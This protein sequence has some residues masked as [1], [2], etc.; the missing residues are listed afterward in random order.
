MTILFLNMET[1]SR[2]MRP[3]GSRTCYQSLFRVFRVLYPSYPVETWLQTY[4]HFGVENL[5]LK[6][7]SSGLFHFFTLSVSLPS[8]SMV[9]FNFYFQGCITLRT[10][11]V[12]NIGHDC[13]LYLM[14]TGFIMQRQKECEERGNCLIKS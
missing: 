10:Q 11:L 8:F 12:F 6:V 3:T 13:S 9:I 5:A 1:C 4:S 7:D 14:V 2:L